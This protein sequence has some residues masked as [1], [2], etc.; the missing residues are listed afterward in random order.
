LIDPRPALDAGIY[1]EQCAGLGDHT[2]GVHI[3]G[4]HPTAVD[5]NLA[6]TAARV[7]RT[8]ASAAAPL[9]DCVGQEES[10]AAIRERE[11]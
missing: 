9:S 11:A 4:L 1:P 7:G 3:D 5:H 2:M 6:S 10:P 8:S